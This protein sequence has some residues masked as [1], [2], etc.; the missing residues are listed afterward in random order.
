MGL[1]IRSNL[2]ASQTLFQLGRNNRSL[3]ESLGRI[4][5]GYRVNSAGDDP[6]GLS[7]AVNLETRNR[8]LQQAIRNAN[9]GVSVIQTAEAATDN[10]AHSLLISAIVVSSAILVHAAP[11]SH[12]SIQGVLGL[13]GF[14]I[15]VVMGL[16]LLFKSWRHRRGSRAMLKKA[17]K[18]R[19]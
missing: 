8:S 19:K 11:D 6:A 12:C 16:G 10:V 15:A 1:S 3:A 18:L 7:V 5:S 17:R 2:M 14:I 4:S 9:D 13:L